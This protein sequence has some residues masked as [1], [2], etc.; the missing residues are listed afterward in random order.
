MLSFGS[1][2]GSLFSFSTHRGAWRTVCVISLSDERSKVDGRHDGNER[3]L[4][5]HAHLP[6]RLAIC[7]FF[8]HL[9][10]RFFL[11]SLVKTVTTHYNY[12]NTCDMNMTGELKLK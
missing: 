5:A 2:P 10:R 9:P 12:S 4:N 6:G 11:F 1:Y 8:S 3:L 7:S